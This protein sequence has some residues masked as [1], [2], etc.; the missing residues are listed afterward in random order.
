MY[1]SA[2]NILI[3]LYIILIPQTLTKQRSKERTAGNLS[4]IYFSVL[5]ENLKLSPNLNQP[6]YR[7]RFPNLLNNEGYLVDLRN[8]DKSIKNRNQCNQVHSSGNCTFLTG[9]VMYH[10]SLTY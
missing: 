1:N 3:P 9:S 6:A 10:K 5:S 4:R 7:I 2:S 8:I